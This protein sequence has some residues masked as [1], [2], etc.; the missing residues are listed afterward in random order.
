MN[1]TTSQIL[2]FVILAAILAVIRN[3]AAPG[4]IDWVGHH[5]GISLVN[6]EEGEVPE[7]A[8]P[9][10][11]PFLT[12]EEAAAF[13]NDPDAVFLD[14]RYPEEYEEGSIP[15]A[16]LLPFEEFDDYWPG[17]E[18]LLTP[19]QPIVTYCSGT[20]CELSLFLARLLKDMGYEHV[21]IFYGGARL[22]ERS[23][24]P[25]DTVKAPPPGA[26]RE[27]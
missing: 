19:D 14:A 7:S 5:S 3:V 27:G 17:V 16:V 13:F 8:S 26:V 23:G 22:W 1:R 4:G 20:E 24:M 15:G 11:P 9:D 2:F 10:D 21:S 12:Y 6:G 25:L 18:P